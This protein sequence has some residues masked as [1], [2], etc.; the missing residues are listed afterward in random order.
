MKRSPLEERHRRNGAR[1]VV[2]SGW[3]LPE[4]FGDPAAEYDAVRRGAGLLDRCQ[5]ALL[6]LT[7]GDRT[8][9]L[10]GM[11]SNDV[12][13]LAPGAGAVAAFLDLHGKVLSDC[14]VLALEEELL[15]ILPEERKE[16][17]A[18]HLER[19]IV[20]DDVLLEDR[21]ATCGMLSV[22]GPSAAALLEAVFPGQPLPRGPLQHARLR[23]G[24]IECRALY[25]TH[26]GE[27]GFDLVAPLCA[28]DELAG[29]L[30]SRGA[31]FSARWVGLGAL[32]TARIEAGIPRYGADLSEENLL[33]EANL[34]HAVSF[35]KG[36]YL[37]QE[38]VERI[39][40]RGHV[41]RRLVCLRV[42]DTTIPEPGAPLYSGGKEGGRITSACFSPLVQAP[43]ALGFAHRDLL[44]AGTRLSLG[45]PPGA[46]LATVIGPPAEGR[47]PAAARFA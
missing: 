2:R 45:E 5:H 35:R 30:E 47:A 19:H 8:A 26:T 22:Q 41:N 11:V 23:A 12:R 38:V 36:C 33:L 17:I 29:M 18:G 31:P 27:P 37:G 4:H 7:G 46:P 9:F 42:E 10:N 40:S 43:L 13:A 21:S 34:D 3:S 6:R 25:V 32:E 24:S 20:A 39:H 15:V 14:A 28:L 16:T 44:G 1:F